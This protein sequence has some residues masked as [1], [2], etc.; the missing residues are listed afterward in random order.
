MQ[1]HLDSLS[2]WCHDSDMKLKQEKCNLMQISFL[3]QTPPPVQPIID[4]APLE[5]VTSLKL[6][7]IT[8]QNDL[9]WDTQV[10]H[11]VS[12]ASRR[13]FILCKLK[14]NGVKADDLVLIYKMYI[15]PLLE[16]GTPVWSSSL[17]NNQSN[18]LERV[19]KRALRMI[20]YPSSDHYNDLL[21]TYDLDSLE[22]RRI[23]ILTRFAKSLLVSTRHRH[24]LPQTRNALSG[25][26]LR[27]AQQLHIPLTRTQRYKQSTIPFA[28]RLLN[29]LT[30]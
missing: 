7:S 4:D 17:T 13:L 9:K 20:T 25:R 28:V 16:F 8:I 26:N 23:L 29:S 14:K 2:E 27:N 24:L 21:R 22:D 15:R 3:R 30:G 12:K 18:D 5:I 10:K 19:Q 6:L 1:T 11:M